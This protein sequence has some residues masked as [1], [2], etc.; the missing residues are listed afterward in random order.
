[1]MTGMFIEVFQKNKI[2]MKKSEIHKDSKNEPKSV[3][4][5]NPA[6][7]RGGW[8]KYGFGEAGCNH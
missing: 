3:L 6:C 2:L 1:M 7:G 4:L 5:P 8:N